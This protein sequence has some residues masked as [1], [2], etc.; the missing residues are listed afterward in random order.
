MGLA[1]EI[2]GLEFKGP[3]RSTDRRLFAQVVKAVLGMANRRDGGR[4]V[5]GVEDLGDSLHPVGLDVTQLATWNYDDVADRIATYADPSV[6]FDL[7]VTEYN[8]RSYVVIQVEEFADVPVLCKRAYDDV[9]RDGACY[10]RPRRK[11]ETTDIP[12]YADMRDLLDLAVEKGV[13]R[14]LAQVQRVGLTVPPDITV[15]DQERFNEQLGDLR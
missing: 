9:L 4:V 12:T 7:E 1:H 2:R 15:T 10:V 11:P 14:L 5:V 8:G 13:R 3:G 6:A